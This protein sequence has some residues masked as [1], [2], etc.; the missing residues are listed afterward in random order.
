MKQKMRI[1]SL[2]AASAAAL[3][4]LASPMAVAQAFPSKPV[5]MVVPYPA[6]GITDILGRLI[7]KVMSEDLKQPILI[8]NRPGANGSIGSDA[9][10]K[11]PADGYTILLGAS[12]THVLH[13]LL[14]KAPPYDG[15]KDFT[16]L[17]LIA[18]TPL[19]LV[20]NTDVPVRSVPELIAWLKANGAKASFGSYGAAS[21]SHLAGELFKSMA[22]VQMTHVPYKGGVPAI[23]DLISGQIQVVF[24]DVTSIPHIRSGK[25]R[26]LAMTGQA[27]SAALP[28]L[29]TV[30][31][32]G[33]PGYQVF[34]WF[35][36]FGPAKMPEAVTA[37]LSA[38]IAAALDSPGMRDQ[39]AGLGLQPQRATG[40][41]VSRLI[42]ADIVKWSKVIADAGIKVD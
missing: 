16:P 21:A 2:L 40:P 19:F 24:A 37:R 9:T 14:T 31:E 39:I 30:A 7:G 1:L 20:V 36:F 32:A 15:L 10:A 11:S 8:D 41:E 5:K 18:A 33:L 25:I 12:T 13:P 4:V 3:A 26:A 38:S 27:R 34:G 23:T 22:G 6:G 28:D 42:Q 29:P 17:G 35:A